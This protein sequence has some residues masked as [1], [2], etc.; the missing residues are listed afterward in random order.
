MAALPQ[1]IGLLLFAVTLAGLAGGGVVLA[2]GCLREANP[3][4]AL[5][6]GLFIGPAV[7]LALLNAFFY[8]AP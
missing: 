5:S 2:R 4:F 7:W 1:P 8:L 6:A 3:H